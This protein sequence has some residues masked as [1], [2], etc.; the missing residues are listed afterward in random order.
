MIMLDSVTRMKWNTTDAPAYTSMYS[1][2]VSPRGEP[3]ALADLEGS[4]FASALSK[5]KSLTLVLP[6]GEVRITGLVDSLAARGT[7]A[8]LTVHGHFGGVD[9]VLRD[10]ARLTSLR[11]L[12]VNAVREPFSDVGL[13]ALSSLTGLSI[14]TLNGGGLVTDDCV[15]RLASSLAGLQ[16]LSL[17]GFKKITDRS[18]GRLAALA[19]AGNLLWM[20]VD[21]SP[22][23]STEGWSA[24]LARLSPRMSGP[25]TLEAY[26]SPR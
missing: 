23:I 15:G 6:A 25:G 4:G 26:W 22:L 13:A 19:E 2:D 21:G 24:L 10:V 17:R 16:C 9:D 18:L 11:R 3:D 14:L 12:E 5:L 8:E 7:L 20:S 1:Y